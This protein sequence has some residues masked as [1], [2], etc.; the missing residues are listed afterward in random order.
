M[1]TDGSQIEV[2]RHRAL[3]CY[4]LNMGTVILRYGKNPYATLDSHPHLYYSDEELK[5]SHPEGVREQ[6][7][8]GALLNMK[9]S[10]EEMR[11]LVELARELPPGQCGLALTDGTLIMWGLEAYPD[12]V[13]AELLEKG[14]L[15]CMDEMLRLSRDRSLALASYI[16]FPRSTD[17]VNALRIAVCPN[18]PVNCDRCRKRECDAVA[19]TQDRELFQRLCDEVLAGDPEAIPEIAP[20]LRLEQSKA[21]NLLNQIDDLF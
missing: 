4:V 6:L 21:Q 2:D 20:E 8:E 13:A 19:G 7:I 18:D 14:Y 10:V 11:Y 15:R 5:I 1:A 3:R 12:F 17:V 16:S 9:R